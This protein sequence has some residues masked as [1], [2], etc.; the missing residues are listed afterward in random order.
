M[1]EADKAQNIAG[2]K[3]G[4]SL[5]K[6]AEKYN[7]VS[8]L[9][10]AGREKAKQA[11]IDKVRKLAVESMKA[12]GADVVAIEK[13]LAETTANI[14]EQY[15]PKKEPKAKKVQ[16]T[17]AEKAMESAKKF[18]EGYL[19][20][21]SGKLPTYTEDMK[22]LELAISS[23]SYTEE[24]ATK[25]RAAYA[26][27]QPEAIEAARKQKEI[28]K[29]N[30][31][32][33]NDLIKEINNAS[34]ALDKLNK[35]YAAKT[36]DALFDNEGQAKDL[37]FREALIGKTQEQQQVMRITFEEESRL[38]KI[39]Q[40]ELKDLKEAQ[41][42]YN[43]AVKNT[44]SMQ[45]QAGRLKADAEAGIKLVADGQR[46]LAANATKIGLKEL[47]NAKLDKFAESLSDAL[48]TGMTK[49]AKAGR[50]KLRDLIVAELE[51]TI[52]LSITANIKGLLGGGQGGGLLDSL[53]GKIT[54]SLFSKGADLLGGLFGSSGAAGA[55]GASSTF[56]AATGTVGT[57]GLSAAAGTGAAALA[58]LST[59]IGGLG[60]AA[61]TTA[62]AATT[63]AVA[64]GGLG[65]S[66]LG[67]IPGVGWLALGIGALIGIFGSGKD[68]I[69]TVLN[70][71]ALF[72]NSLVGL[73]FLELAIGSDE[74]AQGLRDVMYG[75]ENSSP[76]MRKLAGETLNLSVELLR[77]T[78]DIA[79]AANLARNIGTRGMSEKEIAV[80]DY[81][82]KL[83]SQIEAAR[84]GASAAQAAA[85]AE[86]QLAKTRWDLA[87]KLDVL[88]GRK[89]QLEVDRA[90]QLLGV[91]DAVVL[92]LTKAIWV[93][94]DLRT[95]VDKNF[96]AIS[97]AVDAERKKLTEDYNSALTSRTKS[98]KF[99]EDLYNALKG[100]IESI[101]V[102][103]TRKQAQTRL[104]NVLGLA[105]SGKGL[106]SAESIKDILKTL[107]NPNEFEF[108]TAKE[109]K[110]DQAR[111]TE[112]LSRLTALAG[113]QASIE[114]QTL[115]A[116][117]ETYEG[118]M[119][120]LDAVLT[121]AQAQLDRLN[122]IDNSVISVAD[123]VKNFDKSLLTL[124]TAIKNTP[125][126][127]VPAPS[128]IGGGG[129]GGGG[130]SS[131]GSTTGTAPKYEDIVGQ[132]N[133]DIV[134]AYREY[135]KRNPDPTGY[136]YFLESKLTGDKLMQAILGAS[137]GDVSSTDYKTAVSQGYDPLDSVKKFLK[138]KTSTET[139]PEFAVGINNVPYDMTARIHKG[140]RILPAA[141]NSELFARL[142][143]PSE[144]S[145]VL[146]Q[147]FRE[148]QGELKALKTELVQIKESNKKMKDLA[149]KDDA[150]GA[151]PVRVEP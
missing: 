61:T 115:D 15:K 92:S 30:E 82:E 27:K 68:K 73:P 132:D 144:N 127:S 119:K 8:N 123:A 97:R 120:R 21:D 13:K 57:G 83:R 52:T 86:E 131:G 48:V 87:G 74:A 4:E 58:E 80:Y 35:S 101:E 3:A 12:H 63:G 134:A 16:K 121:T 47:E 110:I 89:T 14:N 2:I 90:A 64:T 11:A 7:N 53:F 108:K 116:L 17:E 1:T 130:G 65:A 51:K 100:T 85:Q 24:Q 22:K 70:D 34:D 88:L 138:S 23:M 124:A 33:F 95:A 129:S 39:N 142:Q 59:G 18:F 91:T 94:E 28:T 25:V 148:V 62:A 54:D 99:A 103:L 40:Q 46:E 44:P 31:D 141:D 150:I 78:G 122:G 56:G 143:S 117:K 9:D 45:A 10:G 105:E 37:E 104:D 125:V 93:I 133:K 41:E 66:I 43:E 6:E 147:A 149:E 55:F 128:S 114:Q 75:L 60:A 67:A 145:T 106:P 81:N 84:A 72:N 137:A 79:G 139:I 42:K 102:D 118:E 135:Y 20:I 136:K 29:Q 32:A 98:L 111:T 26:A 96:A 38:R 146:V 50:K 109:Y 69:P 112:K 49:G 151:P 77:A 19:D 36:E 140:E 126:T 71:L 76:T 113:K 107:S 5:K